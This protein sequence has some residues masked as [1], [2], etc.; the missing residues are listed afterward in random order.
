MPAAPQRRNASTARPL[1]IIVT[2]R[3]RTRAVDSRLLR[4]VVGTFL[5]EM[6]QISAADLAIH[7]V[8]SPEITKLNETFLHHAG[9]TDVITFDYSEPLGRNSTDLHGEIFVCVDAAIAQ[10]RQFRTT[11]QSELVR[12]VVHG[13]LHLLGFDDFSTAARRKM[14]RAEDRWLRALSCRFHLTKLA[15]KRATR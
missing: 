9:S 11:W 7:L 3:Q 13:I 6:A 10:A 4:R 5:T 2:S 1:N 15:K 14:K 8:A 12:Y